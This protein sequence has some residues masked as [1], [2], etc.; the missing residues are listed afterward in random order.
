[1]LGVAQ[2]LQTGLNIYKLRA[3]WRILLTHLEP[4]RQQVTTAPF[5]HDVYKW[6]M[7]AKG[8]LGGFFCDLAQPSPVPGVRRVIALLSAEI[9]TVIAG[10]D[11]YVDSVL[12][13]K[14][15]REIVIH[16]LWGVLRSG[17]LNG[18]DMPPEIRSLY[19]FCIDIYKQISTC[20]SPKPFWR[21]S[22]SLVA[23]AIEQ[24]R[25]DGSVDVVKRMGGHAI[26]VSAI[27]S[28]CFGGPRVDRVIEAGHALG[29]YVNLLDDLHD[30]Q[31][32]RV[33]QIATP[34][35]FSTNVLADIDRVTSEMNRCW[36]RCE[37][38]LGEAELKRFTTLAAMLK[39]VWVFERLK[40]I[41]GWRCAEQVAK[42]GA[43]SDGDS[44]IKDLD[45][46]PVTSR[47]L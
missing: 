25:G 38:V 30:I 5:P 7:V 4:K 31:E 26:G 39:L 32:D 28:H 40:N 16:C 2:I 35:S 18:T 37:D 6:A 1:M 20:P 21:E 44:A 34:L 41:Q 46:L 42:V 24:V 33:Q 11:E 43:C 9:Q 36:N 29:A 15:D 47:P 22:E 3:P 45:L 17:R 19:P 8:E 23:A 14:S 10:A 12:R 13:S 27:L